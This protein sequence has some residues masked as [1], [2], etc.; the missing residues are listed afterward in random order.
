M[1]RCFTNIFQVHWIYRH[2][3]S[4]DLP[5]GVINNSS[6]NIASLTWSRPVHYTDVGQYECIGSNSLGEHSATT[7]LDVTG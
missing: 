2:G 7:S 5:D 3:N 1:L 6:G 4:V